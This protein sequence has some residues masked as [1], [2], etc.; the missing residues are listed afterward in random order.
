MLLLAMLLL[1]SAQS[2]GEQFIPVRHD[3]EVRETE[4][5]EACAVGL[6][7]IG[8]RARF[9]G[10]VIYKLQF[11]SRGSLQVL[12]TVHEPSFMSSFVQLDQLKCCL[13]RWSL[14][15]ATTYLVTFTAGTAHETLKYWTLTYRVEGSE[16]VATIRF[17]RV[18]SE[19]CDLDA[20]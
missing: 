4:W 6:T 16:D 12:E 1:V 10:I 15:P 8:R 17:P 11:D 9:R 18:L 5:I 2:V 20:A 7:E 19:P 14:A 13:S 3:S